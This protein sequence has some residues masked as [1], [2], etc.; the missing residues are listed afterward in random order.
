LTMAFML[1]DSCSELIDTGMYMFAGI[2][3]RTHPVP[4]HA[5]MHTHTII[6]VQ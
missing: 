5:H 6:L 4:E 1:I 2:A 3:A